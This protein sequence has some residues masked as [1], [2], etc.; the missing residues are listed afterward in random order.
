MVTITEIKARAHIGDV[1]SALGGGELRG[2]RG[3]AFWR[4]GDGYSIALDPEKGV[5]FDHV[6][7]DGGD[8]LSLIEVARAC[9]FREAVEW[10]AAHMGVTV[11]SSTR[12]ADDT[13]WRADLN[14]ATWWKITAEVMAEDA[15][16]SLSCDDPERADL[17]AM[18]TR[19][20]LGDAALVDEYRMW[21]KLDPQ[22]TAAMTRAGQRSD[23]RI[24]RRLALWIAGGMRA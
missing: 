17:T 15:L 16:A 23:A 13:D 19:M 20:R 6:A 5:W 12:H 14:A 18:L 3:Q 4:G 21:R 7:G 22:L 10:L 8:V 1:W 2:N 11:S 24:Q 9:S